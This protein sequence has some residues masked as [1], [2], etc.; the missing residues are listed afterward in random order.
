MMVLKKIIALLPQDL[1]QHI[2][3]TTYLKVPSRLA[4][5]ILFDN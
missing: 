4:N 5:I 3:G 1:I 2:I